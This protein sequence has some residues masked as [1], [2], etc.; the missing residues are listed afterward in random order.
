MKYGRLL[1][2]FRIAVRMLEGVY[3]GHTSPNNQRMDIVRALI[4][5]H[6]FE[7]H[8]MPHDRVIISHAVRAQNVSRKARAL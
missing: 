1:L 3:P 8:Q 2:F 7:I 4:G 6:A 5:F